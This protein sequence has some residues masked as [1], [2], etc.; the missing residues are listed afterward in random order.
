MAKSRARKLADLI[1]GAGIDIDGNLTFDGGSVSADLTFGDDDKAN[2][3]DASDLQIWHNGTHSFIK[4]AGTGDLY[5]GASSNLALMNSAFTENYLLATSDGAVNLYYDGNKKFE[6]LTGGAKVTGQ[7]T[8]TSDFIAADSGGTARGYLFGTSGGLFLRYNSGSNLQIQEAGSTRVTI[9]AGGEVGIGRTPSNYRLEV[10]A[11]TGGNALKITRGSGTQFNLFQSGNGTTHMGT[12]GTNGDLVFRTGTTVGTDTERMRIDSSGNV[13]IGAAPQTTVGTLDLVG[14]AS[15]YNTSPMIT[16]R[17]TSGQSTARNWSLGNIAIN[18]GDFHIGCGD[19]NSDYFDAT[20]HSKFTIKSNGNVGIGAYSPSSKLH[21]RDT[22]NPIEIRLEPQGQANYPKLVGA[23]AA[24]T[25]D[26]Y[27]AVDFVTRGEAL[28]VDGETG[29]VGIG[30]TAP[31]SLLHV[32]GDSSLGG[33]GNGTHRIGRLTVDYLSNSNPVLSSDGTQI[34]FNDEIALRG[35]GIRKISTSPSDLNIIQ[36]RTGYDIVFKTSPTTNAVNEEVIRFTHDKR[37]GIANSSPNYLLEVGSATQTESNIFSGRVNGDFI[38]N[39][40]KANT[41]LFSIRNNGNS[42]VHVNTQNSARLALGV[43]TSTGTGTIQEDVT[44]LSGGN[45]GI[46][47]ASPEEKLHVLGQGSF[48]NVGNTNR[49]NIIIGPHGNSVNKW[50]TLA[51]THYNEATGS[52]NGSGNAGVMI[53]GSHSTSTTNQVWIGHG[54]YELNPATEIRLGTHTATTHNLGGTTHMTIDSN[55]IIGVGVT[56]ST[57]WSGY[58]A[59]QI[60]PRGSINANSSSANAYFGLANNGYYDGTNWRY[61]AGTIPPTQYQMTPSGTHAWYNASAGTAGNVITYSQDMTLDNDGNLGIGTTNPSAPLHIDAAGMGDIYSGLVQNTTTDTDHYNVI[62][63][64]QGASGSA[65]G[66]IGTGG[67]ATSNTAFRNTFVVGT[68]N[69]TDLVLASADTERMR[70]KS[71]GYVGINTT[72][73]GYLLAV[74]GSTESFALTLSDTARMTMGAD[75]TWNYIKGKS[76]QGFRFST[77]G[78]SSSDVL[79]LQNDG[80]VGISTNNS[81]NSGALVVR[82]QKSGTDVDPGHGILIVNRGAYS[83]GVNRFIDVYTAS[84]GSSSTVYHYIRT[85]INKSGN[86]MYRANIRGYNYGTGKILDLTAVGYA[87]AAGSAP[88]AMQN[89]TLHSSGATIESY[90]DSSNNIVLKI[91]VGTSSYYCG[92]RLDI[93]FTNPTGYTHDFK[94]TESAWST[95]ST[96]LYT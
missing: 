2:F 41:N 43:S 79:V 15:N 10:E 88:T 46:G 21:L 55:G 52:G 9:D 82:S 24:G 59:I 77:T 84:T 11:L 38:F 28:R 91:Y 53:I 67:S 63:W 58:D 60:G 78:A 93:E 95:S 65:T 69:S 31:T 76:G 92:F 44:I 39:L 45:V 56:P 96:N 4:D 83:G 72:N 5:I 75:G 12:S 73:P 90:Y 42:V 20:A 68:Q 7:L 36:D 17:D 49:G 16:F 27:F 62:R 71:S 33:G 8:A 57:G 61:I 35:V 64:M 85:N 34:N 32:N 47:T 25:N 40:S 51:G 13:G 89:S 74:N 18:Y 14:N 37:V 81:Y 29:N 87:Y 30:T 70:I 22:S 54:P 19:T 3:G 6:T 50:A 1:V 48:E 86:V 80:Q 66:M 26:T 94:V 23:S